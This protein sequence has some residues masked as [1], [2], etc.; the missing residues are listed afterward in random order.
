MFFPLGLKLRPT[1][2]NKSYAII[3]LVLTVEE[4][5]F[6]G[7]KSKEKELIDWL[8]VHFDCPSYKGQ[9]YY[10]LHLDRTCQMALVQGRPRNIGTAEEEEEESVK[11]HSSRNSN[12]SYE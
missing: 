3:C 12:P 10:L 8:K 5:M 7:R 2:L 1:F 9:G 6:K 4:L 11:T